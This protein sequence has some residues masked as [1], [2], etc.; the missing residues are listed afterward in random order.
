MK[1]TLLSI[2]FIFFLGA[3]SAQSIS[4]AS[5]N[6]CGLVSKVDFKIYPNPATEYIE[7]YNTDAKVSELIISTWR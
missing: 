4:S 3:L 1:Q 5:C 6:G 2:L 7:F